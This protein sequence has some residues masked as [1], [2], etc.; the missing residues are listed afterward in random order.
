MGAFVHLL[1]WLR[2]TSGTLT[3]H[4]TAY[5]VHREMQEAI[6]FPMNFLQVTRRQGG[7]RRCEWGTD[8]ANQN[9]MDQVKASKCVELKGR[10]RGRERWTGLHG[11]MSLSLLLF[12]LRKE[13]SQIYTSPL[14]VSDPAH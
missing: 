10:D 1:H 7:P 14:I 6:R 11:E 13:G 5:P 12:G 2:V 3:S 9:G 4:P 8:H